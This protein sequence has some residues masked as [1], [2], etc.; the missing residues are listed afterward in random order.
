MRSKDPQ[1]K[2]FF[3]SSKKYNAV[4]C[5]SLSNLPNATE[6]TRERDQTTLAIIHRIPKRGLIIHLLADTIQRPDLNHLS[7]LSRLRIPRDK[8]PTEKL[9]RTLHP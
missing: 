3:V 5:S 8:S 6:K 7:I 4:S 2:I 1:P 9:H